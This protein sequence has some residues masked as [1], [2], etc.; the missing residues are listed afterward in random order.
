VQDEIPV[1]AGLAKAAELRLLSAHEK[2]L[3]KCDLTPAHR[4]KLTPGQQAALNANDQLIAMLETEEEPEDEVPTAEMFTG[5]NGEVAMHI[6]TAP[7]LRW[8]AVYKAHGFTGIVRGKDL[9]EQYVSNGGSNA[10]GKRARSKED[11]EFLWLCQFYSCGTAD[12]D[13]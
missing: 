6:K 3:V 1:G 7:Q 2:Y 11:A 10:K 4:A 12:L 5:P 9:F 13:A 8:Y